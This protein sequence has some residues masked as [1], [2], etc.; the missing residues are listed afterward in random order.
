MNKK[1]L[2]KLLKKSKERFNVDCDSCSN[3]NGRSCGRIEVKLRLTHEEYAEI[4]GH[5]VH[6]ALLN[7]NNSPLDRDEA[8]EKFTE[9]IS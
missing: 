3:C 8:I 4:F 5:D 6:I 1:S 2:K 9:M 7:V